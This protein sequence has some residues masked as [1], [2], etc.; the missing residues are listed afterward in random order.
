VEVHRFPFANVTSAQSVGR[1]SRTL[2]G[3]LPA[4]VQE[5]VIVPIVNGIAVSQVTVRRSDLEHMEYAFDGSWG[6]YANSAFAPA[7]QKLAP[8]DLLYPRFKT[9]LSPYLAT[10]WFDPDQPLRA[11]FGLEA[12]AVYEP[13]LGFLL[14]GAVR[15]KIVGNLDQSTQ[16]SDSVLPHVRS[17]SNIYDREGDPALTELTAAY[18]FQ[19]GND[20]FG[21]VTTGYLERMFGGVSTELLW[22]PNDSRFALGA[23][24]NYVQQRDFDQRFGFQ[25][26]T[27]A[28]GHLTGYWE[29][30]NGLHIQVDAGR[31]LAGD[32]GATLTVDRE[33]RNGWRVGAFATA[34]NVSAADFGEGSFDKGIR[35]TI[36]IRWISGA[37]N[38][39]MFETTIRPVTRDGGAK[40]D[41][42]GRL[43]DSVRGLQKTGLRN[44]WGRFWR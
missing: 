9:E 28:T 39:E 7:D 18:Y 12:R 3:I 8:V 31:Y 35:I 36:P 11:D 23:E 24:V 43:Y 15:K 37:P 40:L 22:K 1:I 32:Y 44:S 19:A 29:M 30:D 20:V 10:A 5:F 21:R 34:T 17:D 2:T 4:S 25:D 26:Y 38:R 27:V 41:V 42:P 6:I 16:V 13:A 14:T 33:F